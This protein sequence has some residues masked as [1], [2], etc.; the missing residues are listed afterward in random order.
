MLGSSVLA[1]LGGALVGVLGTAVQQAVWRIG[2]TIEIPW[3]LVLAEAIIV[4][5]LI[6]IRLRFES[7]TPVL[8]AGVALV[9]VTGLALL[10]AING[11]VVVPATWMGTVWSLAPGITALAI[12]AWPRFARRNDQQA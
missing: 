9:V 3:G 4:T 5:Y 12:I 6:G 11:S 1:G 10:P 7:R 2:T 8:V